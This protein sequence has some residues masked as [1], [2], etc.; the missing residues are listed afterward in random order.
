MNNI[1]ANYNPNETDIINDSYNNVIINQYI[2]QIYIINLNTDRLREKYI[3]IIMKKLNIN[4]KLI[5]VRKPRQQTY[6]NVIKLSKP[7]S[8]KMSIGEVGCYLSHMWC[9]Q[10]IVKNNYKNGIILEDDI[11]VHKNFLSLFE[12][13]L[14][15]NNEK[16]SERIEYDFLMLGAADHG[17]NK[18]NKELIK[19]NIYIPKNHVIMGTHAILYSH[20]GAKIIY[21]YR[22]KYP[23]YFDKNFKEL[24]PFFKECRTGVC[25]P[26]LFTVENSTSNMEHNFGIS[27]YKY[28][29][30]YYNE[31]YDNF[32]FQDYHFIYLDLFPKFQLE[33]QK[34]SLKN[35]HELIERL[36]MNYFNNDTE[37]VEYHYKKLDIDYFFLEEYN[38]MLNVSKNPYTQLY[39]IGGAA[40]TLIPLTPHMEYIGG[41][42]IGGLGGLPL[43]CKK[44]GITSGMLLRE[45]TSRETI[46]NDIK[47]CSFGGGRGVSPLRETI[48]K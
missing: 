22:L 27:K 37:L 4:Y 44:K 20:Y 36:L 1:I 43:Y 41:L 13:Y 17:F 6:N 11:I 39:Y 33:I 21:D 14:S 46:Y 48:Y 40:A 25:Y 32:D 5:T 18:G 29:E 23:V 24:F 34:L 30:Y 42:G 47:D 3:T 26:N 10:N 16:E 7:L 12:R 45:K 8:K 9:L 19:D 28:N 38:E 2:N 15:K 31:C 35:K